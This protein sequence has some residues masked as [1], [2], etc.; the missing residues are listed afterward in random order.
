M[1]GVAS[2]IPMVGE[3]VKKAL[4]THLL[5]GT[6]VDYD[7]KAAGKPPPSLAALMELQAAESGMPENDFLEYA[8]FVDGVWAANPAGNYRDIFATIPRPVRDD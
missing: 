7:A 5:C 4:I 3:A 2:S 6:E 1:N 8:A